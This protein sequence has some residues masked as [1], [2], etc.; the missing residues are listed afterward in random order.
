MVLFENSV[1]NVKINKRPMF[2]LSPQVPELCLV[3]D[4]IMTILNREEVAPRTSLGLSMSGATLDPYAELQSVKGFKAGVT[5]R[6]I[7]GK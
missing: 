2:N 4:A 7:E 1:K 6:L 3:Q 5:L